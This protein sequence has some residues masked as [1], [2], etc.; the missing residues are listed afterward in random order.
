MLAMTPTA[1]T[2][3]PPRRSRLREMPHTPLNTGGRGQRFP[4]DTFASLAREATLTERDP[5]LLEPISAARGIAP[6]Q[7]W[8]GA[9]LV[10]FVIV[11]AACGPRPPSSPTAS[12]AITPGDTQIAAD[13]A[14]PGTPSI[15]KL[16]PGMDLKPNAENLAAAG[17]GER[18][19]VTGVVF[20]RACR[21]LAGVSLH[22]LQTNGDGEYGPVVGDQI[23]ACCYLQGRVLT[24]RAGRYELDTVM[25]GHYKGADPAPPAHIHITVSHPN[26]GRLET[27][28]QFAGDPG[29]L[30]RPD[31]GVAVTPMRDPDGTLHVT[32]DIVLSAA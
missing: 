28:V 18:L 14:P 6:M 2:M 21:P 19:R 25:P 12:C 1:M 20:T 17:R 15:V 26:G 3:A 9:A 5:S 30:H 22:A 13:P 8:R 16:G 29:L 31:P 11:G 32:F 4:R 23:G 24:D 10:S 27:E 7:W